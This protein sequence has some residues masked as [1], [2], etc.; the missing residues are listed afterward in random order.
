M[1]NIIPILTPQPRI[2]IPGADV[3]EKLVNLFRCPRCGNEA[4]SDDKY[5]PACTGPGATDDH[6]MTPMGFVG[7]VPPRRTTIFLR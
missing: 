2:T 7:A 3:R 4:R 1:R 6:E 5:G